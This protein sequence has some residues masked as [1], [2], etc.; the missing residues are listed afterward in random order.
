ML[1]FLCV[2]ALVFMLVFVFVCSCVCVLV[3]LCVCV[4]EFCIDVVQGTIAEDE[5]GTNMS[6][7]RNLGT[8]KQENGTKKRVGLSNYLLYSAYVCRNS[9]DIC[10][11]E[12]A[13]NARHWETKDDKTCVQGTTA[14]DE[15]GANICR[16]SDIW[17]RRSRKI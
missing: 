6:K 13:S 2:C 4:F 14:E 17:R 12:N 5:K 9:G 3:G 7:E 1:L 8:N 11:K 16:R 15:K 10:G